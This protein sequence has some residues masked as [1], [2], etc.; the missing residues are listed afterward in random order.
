VA[1]FNACNMRTVACIH[2]YI[3]TYTHTHTHARTHTHT[4]THSYICI[5]KLCAATKT[6]QVEAGKKKKVRVGGFDGLPKEDR[7][8]YSAPTPGPFRCVSSHYC[9]CI[10][11][12]L[13]QAEV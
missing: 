7:D 8:R 10:R 6:T 11:G 2:A 4:H 3:C 5:Y 13:R 9:V 12:L 1:C